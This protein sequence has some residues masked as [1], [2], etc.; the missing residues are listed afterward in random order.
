MKKTRCNDIE[1]IFKLYGIEAAR[2]ILLYELMTAYQGTSININHTHYSLIVDQM[3]YMGEIIAIDR[4][5][6]SKLDIDPL[7]RASFEKTISHFIN[8]SL[9]N[10]KDNMTS[11]SSRIMMGTVI[12]GGTGMFDILLDT[13]KIENSEYIDEPIGRVSFPPL[14]IEPLINNLLNNNDIHINFFIP[15]NI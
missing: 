6:L 14:K 4:H 13:K 5:G 7:S 2:Q 8:A 10:E 12:K 9:F 11:I 3:T 1:T 15:N